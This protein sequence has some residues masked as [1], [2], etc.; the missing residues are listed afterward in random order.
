MHLGGWWRLWIA[1]SSLYAVVVIGITAF[2]WPEITSITH[3]PSF[4]YRMS[5]QSR[6]ILD[7][8]KTFDPDAYLAAKEQTQVMLNKTGART[9]SELEVA[10]VDADKKGNVTEAKHLANEILTRRKAR[11]LADPMVLEMLNGHKLEVAADTQIQDSTL[12]SK[13]YVR[14]LESELDGYKSTVLLKAFLAWLV[15]VLLICLL[16]LVYRW[17]NVGFVSG[18][19]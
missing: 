18:K 15:P 3:H 12:V 5:E 1:T 9:L 4:I 19:K 16:G 6:V 8:A 10:L 13:E 2:S 11:S 7:K 17:V 14:I